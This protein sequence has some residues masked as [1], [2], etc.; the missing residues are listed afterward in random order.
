MNV[1]ETDLPGV[2]VLEPR[3]WQDARGFFLETFH[4]DH[5]A[6]LGIDCEFVQDNHSSSSRGTLRGLHFQQEQA[7]AK[8]CRVVRGEV[9]DVAVDIRRGSPHFGKWFG[10]VLSEEN[11]RQIFVPRGFAH[12]FL[13]LSERADFLYKCSDFYAPQFERGIAWNDPQIAV[14]WP[15]ETLGL[16]QPI[17]SDKDKNNPLLRELCDEL[18]RDES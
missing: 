7:Q 17:L 3:V 12:G 10:T 4:R 18:P 8:L 13:V 5:Y 2:I 9:F 6:E 11:Q 1:L 14:E 16:T 15:L